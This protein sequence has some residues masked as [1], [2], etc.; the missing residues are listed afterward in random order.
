MNEVRIKKYELGSRKI[1]SQRKEDQQRR[2]AE[3]A[4]HVA[5]AK[6]ERV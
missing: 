3:A 4:D 2:D 1:Q 6:Y 5:F